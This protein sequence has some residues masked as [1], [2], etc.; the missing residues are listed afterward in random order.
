MTDFLYPFI[1]SDERDAAGLLADL[2]ASA[3]AKE[4]ESRALAA[5]TLERLAGE[6]AAVA[7]AMAARLASGGRV[8]TFGN[9]GSS[10]DAAA[11][12]ALMA[13]RDRGRP[14]PARNLAA[15]PGVLSA[16]GNDVGFELVFSRQVIAHGGPADVA[17]GF[18]TSGNSAN[19]LAAFAEAKRLGMLTVGFAGYDGGEM[20]RSDAVDHCLVV[21]SQSVHRIQEAQSALCLALWSALRD[22]LAG[23]ET[24]PQGAGR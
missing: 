18:S 15:D 4:T 20:A 9:G 10:N 3:E 12:A 22:R 1:E 21:R 23:M 7:E 2:A 11:L 6:V 24:S 13:R 14:L 16:L 17:V 19:L 8:L 5:E